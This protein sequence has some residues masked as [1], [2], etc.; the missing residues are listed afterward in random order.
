MIKRNLPLLMTV[1]VFLLGYGFC[2]T[3]FPS[4]ASTR[5]GKIGPSMTY[6]GFSKAGLFVSANLNFDYYHTANLK[7][8]NAL[9]MA[10]VK[11]F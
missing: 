11:F 9:T 5:V 4:F 3:Q 10:L 8:S 7:R 1:L 2:L 6:T